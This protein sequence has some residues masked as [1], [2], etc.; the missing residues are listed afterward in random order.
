M[1]SRLGLPDLGIGVGLRVP[2]YRHILDTRPAVDFF[3]VISENFMV[4]GGKPRYH[5]S[6]VCETYR[7]VQHGVSLGIGSYLASAAIL[8]EGF[9]PFGKAALLAW[10]AANALGCLAIARINLAEEK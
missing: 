6:A 7:V 5:L 3:E 2:H 10:T 8:G 9:G 4:P 1:T